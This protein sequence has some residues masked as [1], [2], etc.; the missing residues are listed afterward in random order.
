M[1]GLL[2]EFGD[3]NRRTQFRMEENANT[4]KDAA[5]RWKKQVAGGGAINR[6]M[7]LWVSSIAPKKCFTQSQI[8]SLLFRLVV[9]PS[10][11]LFL[12]FLPFNIRWM[13]AARFLLLLFSFG[14][15]GYKSDQVEVFVQVYTN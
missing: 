8:L 13:G 9:P 1:V 3:C 5:K 4:D 6:P 10:V 15:L 12:L 2:N 7:F 11:R 14:P